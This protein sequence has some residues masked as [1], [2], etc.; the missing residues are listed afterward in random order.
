MCVL[1]LDPM[2]LGPVSE[3]CEQK[4][5]LELGP[6]SLLYRMDLLFL[7]EAHEAPIAL[8]ILGSRPHLLW[9]GSQ[10]RWDRGLETGTGAGTGVGRG[11]WC[12]LRTSGQLW[13]VGLGLGKLHCQSSPCFCQMR[14]FNVCL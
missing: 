5:V 10:R 12:S 1:C 13:L 9:W 7:L 2:V 4:L 3:M 14:V 11:A 6:L 8:P